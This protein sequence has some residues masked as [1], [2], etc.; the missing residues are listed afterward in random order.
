MATKKDMLA[1]ATLVDPR[2]PLPMAP[3]LCEHLQSE[4]AG[5]AQPV[6]VSGMIGQVIT[7]P[8][9]DQY[10]QAVAVALQPGDQIVK[11]GPVERQL[12]APVEMGTD[13]LPMH[14][15]D[16]DPEQV[17]RLQSQG[18]GLLG[19]GVIE[20]NMGMIVVMHIGGLL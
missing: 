16:A 20:V 18:I 13:P 12:A 9:V 3:M 17:T 5:F 10:V 2:G 19:C 1:G 14:S 11:L 4:R 6:G 15:A 8:A 7:G